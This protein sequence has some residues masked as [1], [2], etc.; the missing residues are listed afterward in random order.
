M[1][2][3]IGEYMAKQKKISISF[4]ETE[5]ELK[6]YNWLL[7]ESEIVGCSGTIKQILFNYMEQ[8]LR[9]KEVKK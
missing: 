2:I 7:E 8:Q 9:D 1:I 5:K 4:K 3:M 6:L